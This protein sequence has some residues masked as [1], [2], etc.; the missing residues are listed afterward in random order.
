LKWEWRK[1]HEVRGQTFV[2]LPEFKQAHF[3]ETCVAEH[4]SNEHMPSGCAVQLA[5]DVGGREPDEQIG[6]GGLDKLVAGR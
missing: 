1:L 5:I 4:E 2:F 6:N 3:P